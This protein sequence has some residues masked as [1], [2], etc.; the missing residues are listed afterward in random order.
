[1]LSRDQHKHSQTIIHKLLKGGQTDLLK[2][3]PLYPTQ[4]NPI[5]IGDMHGNALKFI[6][7][8]IRHQVLKMPPSDYKKI[9]RLYQLPPAELTVMHLNDYKKILARTPVKK[10]VFIRLLGDEL[11]DRGSNDYFTLKLLEKIAPA[12]QLE[13]ILSN[14][15]LEFI[16]VFESGLKN[17]SSDLQ[18]GQAKSLLNLGTLVTRGLV[19]TAEIEHLVTHFYQPHLKMISYSL[20]E[21]RKHMTIYSHAPIGLNTIKAL[22]KLFNVNF[23]DK[24]ATYLANTIEQINQAFHHLVINKKLI[25][26]SELNHFASYESIPLTLPIL[27]ATWARGYSKNDY[28]HKNNYNYHLHYVHGHDGKGVVKPQFKDREINLDN[29]LGKGDKYTGKYTVLFST[30]HHLSEEEKQP[31]CVRRSERIAGQLMKK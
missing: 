20:D 13:I 10:D 14:H 8:L 22:A 30:K 9:I 18:E 24:N 17:Y 27:R 29:L 19:T 11:A 3:P 21:S 12:V 2:Y 6:N 5:T 31:I 28:P 7:F 26:A 1:M 15:A 25:A 16:S 4:D 23:L